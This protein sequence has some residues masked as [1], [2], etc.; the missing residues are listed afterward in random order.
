MRFQSAWCI[1]FALIIIILLGRFES[2]FQFK[3]NRNKTSPGLWAA[4]PAVKA[5]LYL[6]SREYCQWDCWARTE[7]CGTTC[8]LLFDERSYQKII[9]DLECKLKYQCS[10]YT[11]KLWLLPIQETVALSCPSN[12]KR[13][14]LR[15][16]T[17]LKTLKSLFKKNKNLWT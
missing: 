4:S 14:Q 13:S 17:L 1:H 10:W 15:A 5:W 9:N 11:N 6:F 12:E 2:W 7:Y 3:C 16:W 8:C